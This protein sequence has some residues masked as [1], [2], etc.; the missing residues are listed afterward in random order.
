MGTG[1][2]PSKNP[3]Y[4]WTHEWASFAHE[5]ATSSSLLF[6]LARHECVHLVTFVQMA[7]SSCHTYMSFFCW[8]LPM[9]NGRSHCT[10]T[11]SLA[12]ARYRGMNCRPYFIILSIALRACFFYVLAD[13]SLASTS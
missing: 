7:T 5:L 13:G 1:K 10:L 4:A 9:T 11:R 6:S 12:S 2:H 3:I 8:I